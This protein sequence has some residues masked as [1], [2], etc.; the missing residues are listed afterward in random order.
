MWGFKSKAFSWGSVEASG[1]GLQVIVIEAVWV[2]TPWNIASDTAVH[3]F[4]AAFLPRAVRVAEV[5][6]DAAI[7]QPVMEKELGSIIHGEGLPPMGRHVIEPA[8]QLF[9]HGIGM[10]S[11]LLGKQNEAR[12]PL[13]IHEDRR[14][15]LAGM[16]QVSFPMAQLLPLFNCGITLVDRHAMFDVPHGMVWAS[17]PSALAL[18]ARQVVP[19]GII[20]GAAD[21]C[22]D[23]AVNR[24]VAD[25][26]RRL[27][28]RQPSGN[29]FR[30][31]ALSES[32]HH[33][34]TQRWIAL[35]AASMPAPRPA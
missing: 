7:M 13:D 12:R 32:I 15:L 11:G 29:L 5:G 30:R 1:E 10:F 22:V 31:P 16:Q 27:I 33:M 20:V 6:L 23:K 19:P 35:H 34:R 8:L 2:G 3:I 26:H 21:L 4:D 14:S 28:T 18:G 25:A 24:F 17:A 9:C